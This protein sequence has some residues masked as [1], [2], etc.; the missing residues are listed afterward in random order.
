MKRECIANLKRFIQQ[1]KCKADITMDIL[2]LAGIEDSVIDY[3][4]DGLWTLKQALIGADLS[5][6]YPVKKAIY[7]EALNISGFMADRK[8]HST[9]EAKW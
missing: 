7:P 8:T 5:E 3:V 9:F 6:L 4:T 2:H 1:D